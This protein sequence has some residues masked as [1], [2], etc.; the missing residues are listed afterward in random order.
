[1]EEKEKQ[2]Y[3]RMRRRLLCGLVCFLKF[4]KLGESLK[5]CKNQNDVFHE[6]FRSGSSR[7]WPEIRD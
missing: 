5:I 4:K 1:M 6:R 7:S 3:L 2:N